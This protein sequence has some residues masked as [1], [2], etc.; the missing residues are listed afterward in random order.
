MPVPIRSF[1][2]RNKVDGRI[3]IDGKLFSF[4]N[5]K[6]VG[7]VIKKAIR[8]LSEREQ[9]LIAEVKKTDPNDFDAV[10]ALET[11]YRNMTLEH[12]ALFLGEEAR[13]ILAADEEN[14]PLDELLE[15]MRHITVTTHDGES[16]DPLAEELPAT[17]IGTA[18]LPA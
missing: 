7:P 16:E 3:Q 6:R 11:K 5:P 14:Y 18:S 9:Q 8:A 4:K 17:L 1:G 15:L 10:E 13:E 12:L 2:V